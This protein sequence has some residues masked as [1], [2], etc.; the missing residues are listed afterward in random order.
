[1]P[2]RQII[3]QNIM[4]T[5][6]DIPRN[7]EP[8]QYYGNVYLCYEETPTAIIG[9]YKSIQEAKEGISEFHHLKTR[10]TIIPICKWVPEIFH[11]YILNWKLKKMYWLGKM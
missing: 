3:S 7:K 6:Y 8:E 9:K 4:L 2:I 10:H 5:R 1:M 11:T